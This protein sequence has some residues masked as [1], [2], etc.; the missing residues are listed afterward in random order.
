MSQKPEKLSTML[1]EVRRALLIP[2]LAR[3]DLE[4]AH[5][6][7]GVEGDREGRIDQNQ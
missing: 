7:P 1:A 4:E 2:R 3:Q 5:Q 6:Q